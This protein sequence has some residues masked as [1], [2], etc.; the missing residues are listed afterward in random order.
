MR[1]KRE[2]RGEVLRLFFSLLLYPRLFHTCNRGRLC[3]S[4]SGVMFTVCNL[5]QKGRVVVSRGG[6]RSEG[7]SVAL[8]F[9]SRSLTLPHVLL[10]YNR[11]QTHTTR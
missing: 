4:L 6:G 8:P 7:L 5:T 3:V 9:P 11:G 10:M 2:K 1:R